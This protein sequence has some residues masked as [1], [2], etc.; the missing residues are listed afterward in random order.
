M[1]PEG[2]KALSVILDQKNKRI[3]EL[4]AERD[5]TRKGA[6]QMQDGYLE[7]RHELR[8]KLKAEKARAEK[9][10]ADANR[11]ARELQPLQE[12]NAFLKAEVERLTVENSRLKNHMEAARLRIH[13][14]ALR[15]HADDWQFLDDMLMTPIHLMGGGRESGGERGG[16]GESLPQAE[17]VATP[18]QHKVASTEKAGADSLAAAKP[19]A[20]IEP[21]FSTFVSEMRRKLMLNTRKGDSWREN[22]WDIEKRLHEEIA[23][24]HEPG[25]RAEEWADVANF[26]F[27]AWARSARKER[28][29]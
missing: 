9:A 2:E 23:E 7:E 4:E 20:L 11:I 18:K 21:E 19:A 5:R 10:E 26:A 29:G 15:L 22:G 27:F 17:G 12:E 6:F 16:L 14:V 28:D 3:A 24:T 1:T 13:K 25:A 8:E